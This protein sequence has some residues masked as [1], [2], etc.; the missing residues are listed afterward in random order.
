MPVDIVTKIEEARYELEQ[1]AN[2]LTQLGQKEQAGE[3]LQLFQVGRGQAVRV[4]VVG[5]FNQ[6]KSTLV[7]ALLGAKVLPIA[8]VPTTAVLTLVVSALPEGATLYFSD[9]RPPLEVPLEKVSDY[10]ALNPEGKLNLPLRLVEVRFLWREGPGELELYDTPGFNDLPE[11]AEAAR[12]A[13]QKADLLIFMLDARQPLTEQEEFIWQSWGMQFGAKPLFLLNFLNLL[14]EDDREKVSER[15]RSSLPER[16]G[17]KDEVDLLVIDALKALRGQLRNNPEE[18]TESGLPELREK[19]EYYA[20][21]GK[22]QLFKISRIGRLQQFFAGVYTQNRASLTEAEDKLQV[23]REKQ[24]RQNTARQQS[25]RAA[26]VF[27]NVEAFQRHSLTEFEYKLLAELEQ[28]VERWPLPELKTQVEGLTGQRM[29]EWLA[30]FE[31][32]ANKMLVPVAPTAAKPLKFVPPNVPAYSYKYVPPPPPPGPDPNTFES[33]FDFLGNAVREIGQFATNVAGNLFEAGPDPQTIQRERIIAHSRL[34]AFVRETV[35]RLEKPILEGLKTA[36]P[37]YVP[38]LSQ[39]EIIPPTL[40]S[41]VK[42]RRELDALLSK[43]AINLA[44]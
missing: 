11:Q 25:E 43:L 4:V 42:L 20:N 10:L 28:A 5:G 26:S 18:V 32:E 1:L 35:V 27:G 2:L 3:L 44:G 15:V 36:R 14:D 38:K 8:L 30:F 9:K 23:W 29:R 24:L 12:E 37:A 33:P 21:E 16:L 31:R 17:L 22:N 40:E 19:L 34:A 7:D 41:E 6:G 39:P 13:I